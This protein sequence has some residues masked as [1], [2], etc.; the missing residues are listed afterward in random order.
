MSALLEM[1]DVRAS[2]GPLE[3]GPLSLR[4][5]A[6]ELV[7]LV[8]P[9]GAGKSS[10]LALATGEIVPREGTCLLGGTPPATLGRAE[11]ARRAALVR[12][13]S[14]PRMP[15][16]VEELALHGR[17][18]HLT[19]LRFPGASDRQIASA[20][21][22]RCGMSCLSQRD[23]RS[24]SGGEL[25]RVLLAKAL[26]QQSPLLLLDE[27]TSNLDLAHRARVLRLLRDVARDEGMGCI[28]VSHD[29]DLVAELCSRVVLLARGRILATGTPT[30]ALRPDVL[31]EAHGIPVDVE[32][33]PRTGR[34]HVRPRLE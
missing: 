21:L 33:H 25:Q 15:L 19:G 6:G 28:V 8:G 2:R 30:E 27:P 7:A 11:V 31:E 1:I 34:P 3:L 24:L 9:N 16:T 29:L 17:W 12:Q 5:G 4:V 32:L 10:L 26:A 22:E 13:G 23:I 20:A 18:I 14:P